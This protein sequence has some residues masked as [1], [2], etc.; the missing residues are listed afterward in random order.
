MDIIIVIV[1]DI[2]ILLREI[3][4]K[5]KCHIKRIQTQ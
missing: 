5:K 4:E 3:K 1:A 2:R